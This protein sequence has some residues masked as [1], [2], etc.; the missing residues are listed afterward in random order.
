MLGSQILVTL[1]TIYMSFSLVFNSTI[2]IICISP[3]TLKHYSKAIRAYLHLKRL[4]I[5]GHTTLIKMLSKINKAQEMMKL[6]FLTYLIAGTTLNTCSAYQKGYF[7]LLKG[8][9]LSGT[10]AQTS[11]KAANERFCSTACMTAKNR[12]IGFNYNIFTKFCYCFTPRMHALL[13]TQKDVEFVC[14]WKV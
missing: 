13:S 12:T 10:D 3:F 6:L 1:W 4:C 14:A 5:L 8:M 2:P 9:K 7:K 11:F